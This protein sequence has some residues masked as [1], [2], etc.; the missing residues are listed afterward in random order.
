M[1]VCCGAARGAMLLIKSARRLVPGTSRAT[2]AAISV[3]VFVS[4][5][6][7]ESCREKY[8]EENC[9]GTLRCVWLLPS[10]PHQICSSTS[11]AAPPGTSKSDHDLPRSRHRSEE[12][13]V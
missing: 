1:A 2:G 3:S 6:S 4:S 11:I 13:R 9:D 8:Q 7:D 10:G 5:W 12:R